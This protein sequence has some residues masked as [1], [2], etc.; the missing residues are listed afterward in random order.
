MSNLIAMSQDEHFKLD[1]RTIEQRL[2][3]VFEYASRI[4]FAG[5]P[6]NSWA[7]VL[8][9]GGVEDIQRLATLYGSAELSDGQ[10]VPQQ[11][12]LLV[13]LRQLETPAALFN[14][15]PAAHRQ[16]YYRDFLGLK[17]RAA[18]PDRVVLSFRLKGN[19][20]QL[21]LEKGSL[22]DAGQDSQGTSIQ[23]QL[24][25]PL[26][27][28]Q[29]QLT[30][31]RW[32][33]PHEGSLF[34]CVLQ[35]ARQGLAWPQQ[36]SR[37]FSA[38][39]NPEVP[40]ITGRVVASD[41][42]ALSEGKRT[43][44]IDFASSPAP[45]EIY[46]DVSTVNGWVRLTREQGYSFSLGADAPAMAPANGLDGFSL[47]TP[48]LRLSRRDGL[49]VPLVASIAVK[50]AH[51]TQVRFR[52][53]SGS[54]SLDRACLPF[55]EMPVPEI[56]FIS[57]M[58]ADWCRKSTPFSVTLTPQWQGLPSQSFSD[59]YQGYDD[60]PA[61]NQEFTVQPKI[62]SENGWENL[63]S[64]IPLFAVGSGAPAGIPLNLPP[65]SNLPAQPSDSA[66]PEDWSSKVRLELAGQG[67][68]HQQ[69][70]AQSSTGAMLN[71]PYT[72]QWKGLDV[73]YSA[74]DTELGMQYLLTPF[75]YR[76]TDT[77]GGATDLPQLY[78]GFSSMQPGQQLSLYWKLQSPQL[79]ELGFQYLD[80]ANRW[81]S[82]NATVAD[83]T[84]GLFDSGLWMA[85]LPADAADHAPW[86]PA[87]RHWIRI[88]VTPP[89][90]TN[91]PDTSSYPWLQ[92]VLVNSMTATLS[93][94]ET[95]DVM[96]FDRPLPAGTIVQA[97]QTIDGLDSVIQPWPST[98]G[99]AP[100]SPAVF[101]Q[102]VAWQLSHRGRGQ[103]WKDMRALL[104]EQFPE[105]HEVYT[106][107]E[108]GFTDPHSSD[109]QTITVIPNH[110]HMDNTDP[111]RPVFNMAR[112]D[113]MRRYLQDRT[114]PWVK[115]NLANP[116]YIDVLG[117]YEIEFHHAIS[118]EYGYRML[119]QTLLQRYIPWA[120]DG[121]SEAKPGGR[122]D[123]YEVLAFIQQQQCVER[124]VRLTLNDAMQSV[125]CAPT[126]V[127]VPRWE[128]I[129][130]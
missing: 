97:V 66:D 70:E 128:R 118:P 104:L 109:L 130:N 59:W 6:Q 20:S 101:H 52:T 91:T 14:S 103:S 110:G 1:D 64:R 58:A 82:L 9:P 16:L 120:W 75:G 117:K 34:S 81:R 49:P 41:V 83:G 125:E 29:G 74:L 72:P 95:L 116:I 92:A 53:D 94:G 55:G 93:R 69:F 61:T 50:V 4:P 5:R 123:Y 30:D 113:A 107:T 105:I 129:L 100:E 25:Q 22:F 73:E 99:R 35:D 108:G 122:L 13:L 62:Y 27:A 15:L 38:D 24:D 111:L 54:H 28:N 71:P 60:A 56:S 126:R 65:F 36:G 32:C 39:T 85:S 86:M 68:L 45:G 119:S 46:A 77:E 23:Y 78:L 115:L 26:Q 8:F 102:R 31:V 47:A 88:L 11:A 48:I 51:A 112:L 12:F 43:I 87:G 44:R 106:P 114:S 90:D 42:L 76:D 96:H 21:L 57:L 121:R 3:Y 19:T 7:Q 67:F 40:V 79:L 80:R 84:G 63:G 18:E 17:E 98:G 37:L 127:L 10:L 33:R 2:N 89:G 124:V